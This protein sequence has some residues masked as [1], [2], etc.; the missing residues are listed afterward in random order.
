[1]KT[2]S[3]HYFEEEG[4]RS[5]GRPKLVVDPQTVLSL[6]PASSLTVRMSPLSD[7]L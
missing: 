7:G 3:I 5:I 1:M 4:M 2:S 6:S